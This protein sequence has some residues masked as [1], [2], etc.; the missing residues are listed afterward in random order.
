MKQL[1]ATNKYF[2]GSVILFSVLESILLAITTKAEVTLWVNTHEY[3]MLDQSLLFVN[4]GGTTLFSVAVVLLFGICKGWRMVL[5]VSAC[6]LLVMLVTQFAKHILFPGTPRPTL[7]FE[8]GALR[9]IDGVKQLTTES[10]PSGHTSASF[11]LAT[12]FALYWPHKQWHWLLALLAF[13]VG[14]ARVYLSQ[15]FITDVYAGMLLGVI[16]TTLIYHFYPDKWETKRR[17]TGDAQQI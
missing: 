16:L 5:K 13:T 3:V 11:A 17:S 1:L 8:P 6:L 15:H 12:F 10:F 9:L 2:F 4:N 14:Y 7:Y